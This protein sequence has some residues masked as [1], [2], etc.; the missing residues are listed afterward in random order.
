M[1]AHLLA[2]EIGLTV[3]ELYS[4]MSA[5]EFDHWYAFFLL[6]QNKWQPVRA[7]RPAVVKPPTLIRGGAKKDIAIRA[8]FGEVSQ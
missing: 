5:D 6:R 4:R 1:F 8:L 2:L 3:E 7:N